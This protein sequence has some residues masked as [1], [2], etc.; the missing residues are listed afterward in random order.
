MMTNDSVHALCLAISHAINVGADRIRVFLNNRQAKVYEYI[1]GKTI[2]YV[3]EP[4]D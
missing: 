2:R 4:G 3:V 1:Y